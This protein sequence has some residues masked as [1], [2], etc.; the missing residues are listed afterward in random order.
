MFA[1]VWYGA[2]PQSPPHPLK[3]QDCKTLGYACWLKHSAL[4]TNNFLKKIPQ[5]VLSLLEEF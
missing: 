5:R 1:R 2:W 3:T 4:E